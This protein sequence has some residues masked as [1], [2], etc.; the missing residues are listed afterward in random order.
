MD[1]PPQIDRA[2]FGPSSG[3]ALACLIA[4]II[5][6]GLSF[7][8][9]GM[10]F[11]LAGVGIGITS[12]NRNEGGRTMARWGIGLSVFGIV[13]SIGFA[14]LYKSFISSF[15]NMNGAVKGS[16]PATPSAKLSSPSPLPA[17]KSMFKTTVLWSNTIPGAVAMTV[18]DWDGAGSAEIL[19]VSGQTLHVLDLAGVEKSQVN[20]PGLYTVIEYGHSKSKGSR[21]LGY[22]APWGRNLSVIDHNGKEAWNQSAWLGMNGAHWADLKSDG[23]EGV[24]IGY[25]GPRGI[26]AYS[27]EG[28]DLWKVRMGNVWSHAFVPPT[29]LHPGAIAACEASGS[30][31]LINLAGKALPPLRPEGGYF[32]QVAAGLMESNAVQMLGFANGAVVAFDESGTASWISPAAW[33]TTGKP[34]I[35]ISGDLLGDKTSEWIFSD[36]R[37]DLEIATSSGSQAGIISRK[38]AILGAAVTP[39]KGAGGLLLVLDGGTI[40]A[41]SFA[42]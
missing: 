15:A 27:S 30:V 2:G 42:P 35:A 14:I 8:V 12:L 26:A 4:G 16:P 39:R 19:V 37:G 25:N 20:L 21:L 3:K 11:G 40:W 34:A 18:G 13:A 17:A 7:M 10:I 33:N 31:V 23:E 32:T 9:V 41:Y 36:A 28:K 6:I 29:L 1:V 38:S 22:T 5:A 24:V